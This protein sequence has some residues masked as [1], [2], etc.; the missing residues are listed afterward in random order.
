[1]NSKADLLAKKGRDMHFKNTIMLNSI[2][3]EF[4]T[5]FHICKF[6]IYAYA[7]YRS[8]TEVSQHKYVRVHKPSESFVKP[9]CKNTH[10]F[11]SIGTSLRCVTC[12]VNRSNHIANG[13]CKYNVHAL[14]FRTQCVSCSTV[15]FLCV[16]CGSYSKDRIGALATVC[17]N[18]SPTA[19]FVRAK[20][21]LLEGRHPVTKV[22][23][24]Q[25]FVCKVIFRRLLEIME[26]CGELEIVDEPFDLLLE[27]Q[28]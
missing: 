11:D 25:Y 21:R 27:N 5:M 9:L 28:R 4:R 6:I 24:S 12:L 1:M 20:S 22:F 15:S 10:S 18:T 2:D 7:H 19:H 14:A 8:N 23:L 13:S 17:P 26:G 3:H 16:Y